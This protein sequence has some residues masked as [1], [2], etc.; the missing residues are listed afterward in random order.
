MSN[1]FK[2]PFYAKAALIFISVFAFVFMLFVGRSIVVPIVFALILAILINPMVN[3]FHRK[4]INRLVSIFAAVTITVFAVLGTF[5]LISTRIDEFAETYPQ[6]K[7]KFE[8][9][10]LEGVRWISKTFN[11]RQWQIK[12]WVKE[13]KSNAI[14]DFE[15]RKN[16]TEVGRVMVTVLLLPVYLFMI[17]YYKP[18]LLEF[19]HRTFQVAYHK[20]VTEVLSSTKAII[21]SYIV[22]LFFEMVIMAILNSVGLLLLGI[23]YA[24]ILGVIG[25]I[26][27][28]IPYIGG[29]IATLLAMTIAF[30]TK[31]SLSYPIIV[32]ILYIVIQLIDNNFIVPKIVASRVQ[33]NA[34]ISI[35]AV[36]IG[37]AIWGIAGMFLSIPLTAILKVIFD[38]IDPLKPWGYLLGNIVPTSSGFSRFKRKNK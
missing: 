38:H 26:L 11:V 36:L 1:T 30:V 9:T 6:L 23:Q 34:L 32:L 31:D 21:Q 10:N 5:F 7:K 14:D 20:T 25:A 16:L 28:I 3:Y 37:G 19:V 24:I 8:A 17:L 2:I 35:I 18:L 33:L 27:N 22:G 15:F 12:A 4:G 29:I 13:T